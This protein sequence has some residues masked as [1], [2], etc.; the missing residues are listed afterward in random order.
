[1][2]FGPDCG[3]KPCE[4]ALDL[5]C[6]QSPHRLPVEV[7]SICSYLGIPSPQQRLILI[8]NARADAIMLQKVGLMGKEDATRVIKEKVERH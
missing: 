1:M 5:Q 8:E 4:A 7:G 3:G 6:L 2:Y